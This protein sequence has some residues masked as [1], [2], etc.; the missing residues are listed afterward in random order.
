ME[1]ISNAIQ[2]SLEN[3]FVKIREKE[4]KYYLMS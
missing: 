1:K 4:M 2:L 3:F